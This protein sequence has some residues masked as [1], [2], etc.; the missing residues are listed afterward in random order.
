M[1]KSNL[2][3]LKNFSEH[4]IWNIPHTLRDVYP[5]DLSNAEIRI[6]IGSR[7]RACINDKDPEWAGVAGNVPT[8][9]K[10]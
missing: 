5:T 1:E 10:N 2:Y 3:Q 4:Y 8:A 7:L 9:T 6:T